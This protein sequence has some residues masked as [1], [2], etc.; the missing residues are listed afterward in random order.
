MS[1]NATEP[2]LSPN[3]K[4]VMY[5]TSPA[6]RKTILWESEIDSGNTVKI[7]SGE[8]LQTGTWA[9][10][11]FH[12]SFVSREPAL[13]ARFIS[14]RRMVANCGNSLPWEVRPVISV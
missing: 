7:A 14:S 8:E 5:I 10:D 6:P 4:R 12:L 13:G 9:S 3:G 11:N 2:I 1:E